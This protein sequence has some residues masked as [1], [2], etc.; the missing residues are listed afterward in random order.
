VFLPL[1]DEI[2]AS[3]RCIRDDAPAFEGRGVIVKSA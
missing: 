2:A 3:K 1:I